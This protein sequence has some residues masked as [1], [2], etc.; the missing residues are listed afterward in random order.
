MIIIL[1][2]RIWSRKVV[3][4]SVVI[5]LLVVMGSPVLRE[6]RDESNLEDFGGRAPLWAHM[7]DI[8]LSD[9]P[10]V[11]LGY[12]AGTRVLAMEVDPDYATGHSIFFEVFIGAGI[13][14]L[15][16][17]C[18]LLANL[19]LLC[20]KLVRSHGEAQVFT[21]IALFSA[22][23]IIGA[24]WEQID[25]TP[26]GFTFWALVTAIPQMY[27]LKVNNRRLSYETQEFPA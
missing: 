26:F 15:T 5:V 19:I 22:L 10:W 8:L 12:A 1:R 20:S 11:G 24:L 3:F 14:G 27:S 16:A 6:V 4:A 7:S 9:S 25:S 2:P 18:A 21:V 17:L 23:L 13:L